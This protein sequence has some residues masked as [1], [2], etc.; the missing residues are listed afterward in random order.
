M[1]IYLFDLKTEMVRDGISKL[2]FLEN[3]FEVFYGDNFIRLQSAIIVEEEHLC[4]PDLIS[5]EKYG[6]VDYVDIILKFNQI[7]NPFSMNIGDV[8]LIPTIDSAKRFYKKDLLI[9]SPQIRDTKALFIDPTKASQKDIS[10]LEYLKKIA[11]KRSSGSTEIKPTNLLRAGEVP[12]TTDGN[13][14]TF[15]PNMSN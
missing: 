3:N 9:T 10:R 8:L 11:S 6:L 1:E 5:W 7:T 12:F 13:F 15:A 4:R 2:D 14:I